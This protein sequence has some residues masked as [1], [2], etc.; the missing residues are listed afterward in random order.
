MVNAALIQGGKEAVNIHIH[1]T[2]CVSQRYLGEWTDDREAA[3]TVLAAM[4]HSKQ[5]NSMFY[6]PII[7]S[8]HLHFHS[9]RNCFLR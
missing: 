3:Y 9:E 2:E 6:R 4:V 7:R 8:V 5:P 1:D